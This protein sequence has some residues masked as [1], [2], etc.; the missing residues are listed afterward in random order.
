MRPALS[1]PSRVK[2]SESSKRKQVGKGAVAAV[3][4]GRAT[5]QAPTPDGISP[6]HARVF[7]DLY[8]HIHTGRD[9]SPAFVSLLNRTDT[10]LRPRLL[11]AREAARTAVTR[12]LLAEG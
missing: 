8:E 9:L 12:H 5:N 2:S 6:R 10:E 4:R 11:A 3:D 1:R 7:D